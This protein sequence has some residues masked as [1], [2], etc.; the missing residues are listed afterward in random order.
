VLPVLCSDDFQTP[1]LMPL[2]FS[3]DDMTAGWVRSG[4]PESEAMFLIKSVWDLRSLVVNMQHADGMTERDS[5]IA[6][7]AI[8]PPHPERS[9]YAPR[10]MPSPEPT[11]TVATASGS[12]PQKTEPNPSKNLV[13]E[14][15]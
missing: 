15:G 11:A 1:T 10:R 14:G 13:G 6:T 2:F 3:A 7:S 4:R 5:L 12:C 9:V 8:G